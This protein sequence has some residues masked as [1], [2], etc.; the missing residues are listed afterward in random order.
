MIFQ[1]DQMQYIT[2]RIHYTQQ[3]KDN[4]VHLYAKTYMD[5]LC[6]S[7]TCLLAIIML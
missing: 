5:V 6:L 2:L 4:S 1:H 3:F 7:Q